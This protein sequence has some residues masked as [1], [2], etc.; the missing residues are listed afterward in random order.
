MTVED[1][2]KILLVRQD[3]IGDLVLITPAIQALK[4]AN[5]SIE[6]W[7]LA[8]PYASP[9]LMHNPHLKG[10]IHW[11]NNTGETIDTLKEKGF[12]AAILF[13]PTLKVSWAVFRAGIPTRIGGV[14]RPY[15]FLF[16]HLVPMHRSRHEKREWEYNLD[17]LAPLGSFNKHRP[18]LYLSETEKA[19]ARQWWGKK[20]RGKGLVG[21]Y[22]GGG[23]E[24]RW[25]AKSFVE[26]GNLLEQHGFRA[27]FLWGKG[28]EPLAETARAAGFTVAPPTTVRELASLLALCDAV[29]TNNTGPM[30]MAA[31]LNRP[32]VQIFDPRHACSPRRWGH[33]GKGRRILM[34]PVPP[35]KRCS[36][37][38][39]HYNCME[40]L[41]P[42]QVF[43]AVR[44]VVSEAHE[45]R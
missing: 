36:T 13:F 12:D 40:M 33:Q 18:R 2:S 9:V 30:H 44:E 38:C 29:V 5:P 7:V 6:I 21:L 24:I 20:S 16:T 1:I 35:C 15:W 8:S 27:L 19:W 43:T 22:L 11:D 17:V 32:L 34:P 41:T 10:I 4:E 25:P 23:K 42:Q 28:E 31:A 26:L 39:I 14:L 45:E 3:K 37:N